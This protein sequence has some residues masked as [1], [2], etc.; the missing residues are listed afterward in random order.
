MTGVP[1]LFDYM[2]NQNDLKQNI[3]T[4]H[5]NREP[6]DSGSMLIFGGS[7]NNLIA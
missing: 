3:F 2:I 6:G 1:T 5:L 4:F 7:D